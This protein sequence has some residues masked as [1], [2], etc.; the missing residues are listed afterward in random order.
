[1]T[2]TRN[3]RAALGA[4]ELAR[5]LRPLGPRGTLVMPSWTGTDDPRSVPPAPR[6][7]RSTASWMILLDEVED[8]R[9]AKLTGTY[10][11]DS[12]GNQIRFSSYIRTGLNGDGSIASQELASYYDAAQRLRAADRRACIRWPPE[13]NYRPDKCPFQWVDTVKY[14]SPWTSTR[15]PSTSASAAANSSSVC[16]PDPDG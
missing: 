13:D 3:A 1:M 14:E 7:A 10:V 15:S 8:N 9:D 12:A 5:Q 4:D 6:P 11:Y 16:S 2:G